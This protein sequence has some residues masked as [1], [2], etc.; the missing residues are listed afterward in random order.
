MLLS[1]AHF[2]FK[3][4]AVIVFV[5]GKRIDG[6]TVVSLTAAEFQVSARILNLQLFTQRFT[7]FNKRRIFIIM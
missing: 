4:C 1:V 6:I 3:Y 5:T 7:N 2:Y